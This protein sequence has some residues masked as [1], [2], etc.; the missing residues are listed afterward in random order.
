[1]KKQYEVVLTKEEQVQV[2]QDLRKDWYKKQFVGMSKRE[3]VA[4][5][6]Q[7]GFTYTYK[8]TGHGVPYAL[9]IYTGGFAATG[10]M[11]FDKHTRRV[12]KVM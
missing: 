2:A 11:Y 3:L 9:F 10:I 12:G 5:C 1:M 8:E 4:F 7:C 6:E